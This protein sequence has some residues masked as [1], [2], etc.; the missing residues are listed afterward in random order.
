[1]NGDGYGKETANTYVRQKF[2]KWP[3]PNMPKRLRRLVVNGALIGLL[4]LVVP[5]IFQWQ[6]NNNSARSDLVIT[7]FVACG[8]TKL[9]LAYQLSK[10]SELGRQGAIGE[11]LFIIA[12]F[13]WA[14]VSVA[15]SSAALA[16]LPR[17]VLWWFFICVVI[18]AIRL[19]Y[20]SKRIEYLN[21]SEVREWLARKQVAGEP[22]FPRGAAG[23]K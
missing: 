22:P 8:L 20:M 7:L 21:S 14:V 6:G 23:I 18:G 10:G 19:W 17:E 1:M 11:I 15:S 3:D 5:L 13:C 12:V 4:F 2:M 9:Y 16:K